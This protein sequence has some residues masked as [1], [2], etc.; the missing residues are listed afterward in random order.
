MAIICLADGIRIQREDSRLK[1]DW[2]EQGDRFHSSTPSSAPQTLVAQESPYFAELAD[3]GFYRLRYQSLTYAIVD[4]NQNEFYDAEGNTISPAPTE[5]Q[6]YFGSDA[7][8]S[9]NQPSYSDNGD[10]TVSDEVTGLMWQQVP[11]AAFYSWTEAQS[12]AENLVLAGHDDWR[13]PAIKELLSLA[14]FNGSSRPAIDR[15][16]IDEDFFVI[17][18]PQTIDTFVPASAAGTK[19]DIDGQFWS[20]NAYV[21]RTLNNDSSTFGFNFIDGRIKSYPNGLESGPTGTA[22]V[23]CVRGNEQYGKNDFQDNGD[24]TITDRAT[25]LMWLKNDSGVFPDAGT[26]GDGAMN[27]IQALD[28]TEDL[29]AAGYS[30]W[31]LPNAKELQSIVDYSRAPDAEDPAARSAAIDPIF[32]LTETESWFWS[33][34]SLGDDLFS[35]ALYLCFGRALAVDTNTEL[36]TIN[37]H[38]AGAMR[39]DP[40]NG[41]PGDYVGSSG[42]HGPQN[43]QVRVYNYVRPVR[44]ASSGGE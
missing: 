13:L 44:A 43:D 39:S 7:T 30:D 26:Q 6:P 8:Y 4:T 25:G 37:A 16:Y 10:G 19:R 12:Y 32:N 20:S 11:Q 31:R 17:Y 21:G 23:R 38:G 24:G 18:D 34:T 29:E 3:G 14:D 42:G 28:W 36:P 27:W 1:L 33:S 9:G 5:G 35:W 22:F 40:K 41:E 15:P 2:S